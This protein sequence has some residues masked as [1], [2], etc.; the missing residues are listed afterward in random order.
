MTPEAWDALFEKQNGICPITGIKL[1]KNGNKGDRAVVHHNHYSG[2]TEGLWSG[3]ANLIE[4]QLLKLP[5]PIRTLRKLL[6]YFEESELFHHKG[7]GKGG[8]AWPDGVKR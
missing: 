2:H 6:K 1:N 7:N 8:Y 4:G 3:Y 5:N